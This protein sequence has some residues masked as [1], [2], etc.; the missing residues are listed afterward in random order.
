M[1]VASGKSGI[2]HGGR[3]L[4]DPRPSSPSPV[5][6][7][8]EPHVKGAAYLTRHGTRASEQGRHWHVSSAASPLCAKHYTS[9]QAFR[10]TAL[11]SDVVWSDETKTNLLGL[12]DVHRALPRSRVLGI[13]MAY[14]SQVMGRARSIQA[15][16]S[17]RNAAGVGAAPQGSVI[18]MRFARDCR[19]ALSGRGGHCLLG[20]AAKWP[21]YVGVY[22]SPDTLSIFTLQLSRPRST[23]RVSQ[24]VFQLAHLPPAA[25]PHY[26]CCPALGSD[27]LRSSTLPDRRVRHLLLPRGRHGMIDSG[28]TWLAS[29][30]THLKKRNLSIAENRLQEQKKTLP[31]FCKNQAAL[32]GKERVE[33]KV[34]KVEEEE[35]KENEKKKKPNLDYG[36]FTLTL[37]FLAC[38]GRVLGGEEREIPSIGMIPCTCENPGSDIDG[39]R[40]RELVR[41]P[42]DPDIIAP[43]LDNLVFFALPPLADIRDNLAPGLYSAVAVYGIVRTARCCPL[44]RRA[45]LCVSRLS[46]RPWR[47]LGARGPIPARLS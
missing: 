25:S 20:S 13:S 46:A 44:W 23:A 33:A 7:L 9:A 27:P 16:P 42:T 26:A 40:T 18:Q 43:E 32:I 1:A 12:D 36:R 45:K 10:L 5:F 31:P 39:T 8:R 37:T 6:Y 19:A 15:G 11:V 2:Q 34:G 30:R 35:G 29:K 47:Q 38:L 21:A 14:Y 3:R 28:E 22:V 24:A 41:W 4:V 17:E